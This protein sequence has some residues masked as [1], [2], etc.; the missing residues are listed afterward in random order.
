MMK[1]IRLT[2]L[3]LA[4]MMVFS[5]ASLAEDANG[6]TPGSLAAGPVYTGPD[7][8][9]DELVVG[10]TTAMNGNFTT[11]MWGNNT[12]D[13]DVKALVNGYN[14]IQWNRGQGVFEADGS[15]V[16]GMT[17]YDDAEGNR[18][19]VMALYPD[20]RY[21]DGTAINAYDYAFSILLSVA[22]EVRELGGSTEN[23][24]AILG[25]DAYKAGEQPALKGVRILADN[26]LSITISAEY[27]PFFYELGLL[28]C[29]PMPVHVIAPGCQVKDNGE[30]VC[31]EGPFTA[32]L[33]RQTMLDPA[34]GY[35]SHPSVVSGPYQLVSFDGV[36][37]EFAINPEF[38][39]TADGR[40]P[41]IR[42]LVFTLAENETMMDKLAAGE[43]GLLNK[44]TRADSIEGGKALAA[45]GSFRAQEYPRIGQ[46]YISFC[47]EQPAL[48]SQ[49]VRQAIALC[50]DK[51][52]LVADYA[53]DGGLR[54]DGYYGLGQWMYQMVSGE[55][56][57]QNMSADTLA[58]IDALSLDGMRIY[59][60]N[61]DEAVKLL[62]SDGWTLN[63]QGGAYVPG[64]DD[65][66]CKE[67]DG[68][69][70]ALELT[71]IYPAGNAVEKSLQANFVPNL[72]QAG[73]VLTL[74]PVEFTQLLEMNYRRAERDCDM[75]YMASNFTVVFDPT[76]N[77]D[78]ADAQVGQVNTTAIEDEELYLLAK[79]MRNTAPG[80]VLGYMR[81]W[82]AFQERYAE[83][84]PTIP[85]YSN[86]YV[87]FYTSCVQNYHVSE[88]VT[89]SQAIVDAYMSDPVN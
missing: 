5:A 85:V 65:V 57:P 75:I 72:A 80:D 45:D 63:R 38:K 53:G 58:A 54:V 28:M 39:G 11:Q 89:W 32:E 26:M 14:L 62:E 16:S 66:R 2:A 48:K 10:H 44:V 4:L 60:L 22:K 13:L 30:G 37:A 17:T 15:V 40:K 9:Y 23:Y 70:T 49:A 68:V 50:L 6:V 77:F 81:K 88:N 83:V 46:S 56:K 1:M 84:L 69:L 55:L 59:R 64:Q 86:V 8:A 35:V 41:V 78:P 76:D 31:I 74:E 43:F 25:M 61:A 20:L 24:S 12:S 19:Y 42:K 36:T 7:Y 33:L 73:I 34:T 47:C 79:D 71:L 82:I 3:F 18:T 29:E 67:I 27:R 21:S 87:D 52:Q 51:D